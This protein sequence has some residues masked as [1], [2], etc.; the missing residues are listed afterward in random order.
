MIKRKYTDKDGDCASL[1]GGECDAMKV[2]SPECGSYM[3]PFYKPR[4]C[5]DWIKIEKP[6]HVEFYTPEEYYG[7]NK[8]QR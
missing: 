6:K 3:C 2:L 5:A 8:Q 1:M 4:E 7:G